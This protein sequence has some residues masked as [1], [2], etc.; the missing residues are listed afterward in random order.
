M[1]ARLMYPVRR[2][3]APAA[4]E[5]A[6]QVQ[7]LNAEID[8]LREEN[9]RLHQRTEELDR[10]LGEHSARLAELHGDVLES[11]R[12]NVRIAELADVVTE[13]VLPLHDRDIDPAALRTLRPDTV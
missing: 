8:R 9:E 1:V 5:L 13:L 6:G 7:H 11:R 12:L 2:A 4:L 3:I 10:R